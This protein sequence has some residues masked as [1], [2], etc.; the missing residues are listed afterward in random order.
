MKN[1]TPNKRKLSQ[2]K[3]LNQFNIYL[4]QKKLKLTKN[5]STKKEVKLIEN[6]PKDIR[7]S[8]KSI[9]NNISSKIFDYKI[10][11]K[12]NAIV[13]YAR[14]KIKK[15]YRSPYI[16]KLIEN[17]KFNIMREEEKPIYYCLYK[18][19]DI[20]LHKKSRFSVNF[21]ECEIFYDENDYLIRCFKK[22]EFIIMMRYLL[23]YV[24]D[25]D[26]YSH[27]KKQV[28]RHKNKNVMRK[29]QYMVNNNY[30]YDIPTEIDNASSE[31]FFQLAQ[32]EK[33]SLIPKNINDKKISLFFLKRK[34]LLYLYEIET[35]NKDKIREYL[36]RKIPKYYFIKDVPIG[37]IPNS[38]QNFFSLGYFMNNLI[39]HY[40]FYKKFSAYKN[41]KKKKSKRRK[42][43]NLINESFENINTKKRKKITDNE[44]TTSSIS[45]N[46]SKILL[47]EL[48]IES[49][50]SE[51]FIN[52]NTN[53]KKRRV[54]IVLTKDN[55][56]KKV[57]IEE[58]ND[59]VDLEK[60]IKNMENNRKKSVKIE[61][62]SSTT[63]ILKK[64]IK[65]KISIVKPKIIEYF[66]IHT[67][68]FELKNIYDEKA[69]FIERTFSKKFTRAYTNS[70]KQK[71][72]VPKLI[73]NNNINNYSVSLKNNMQF[74]R[75]RKYYVT[76]A[77][78]NNLKKPLDKQSSLN[79][80][81][82][83]SHIANKK[84]NLSSKNNLHKFKLRNNFKYNNFNFYSKNSD[85]K[86]YPHH[87]KN[88]GELVKQR[89]ISFSFFHSKNKI[90]FKNTSDFLIGLKKSYK[91]K[92]HQKEI[93]REMISTF[94]IMYQKRNKPKPKFEFLTSSNTHNLKKYQ[95]NTV[96]TNTKTKFNSS[97]GNST[98]NSLLYNRNE[99]FRDYIN[100]K[101]IFK[102]T[103][104]NI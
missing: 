66:I 21:Y 47:N 12:F 63:S 82:Y 37:R 62:R 45:E 13:Q 95:I 9:N 31:R 65:K 30:V 52:N 42:K 11:Y 87:F 46:N 4:S 51:S 64:K 101:G 99:I 88:K 36:F 70:F 72:N 79:S 27:Y 34:S 22:Y 41:E 25:K 83:I 97:G 28:Y 71:E 59:I 98:K 23:A 6:K 90:K 76:S 68:N 39:E 91:N 103:K 33:I 49:S 96:S 44:E 26:S 29:F 56:L 74:L 17:K 8:I 81:N 100:L 1:D 78:M 55:Q 73:L 5:I 48:A 18:V 35:S 14:D 7:E 19:N 53:T 32:N 2:S 24:Y 89:K 57:N 54:S 77:D 58:N 20:F 93:I 40:L 80:L 50:S 102:H 15:Q 85:I 86:H 92:R 104:I 75:S 84:V 94:G 67:D 16:T 61:E 38:I 69:N 43:I 3:Y 10:K 60:L